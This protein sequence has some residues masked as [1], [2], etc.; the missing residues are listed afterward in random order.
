MPIAAWASASLL[1]ATLLLTA[2]EASPPPKGDELR[3]RG[4]K[5]CLCFSDRECASDE[6]RLGRCTEQVERVGLGE[7]CQ[8]NAYCKKGFFCD[9]QSKKCAHAVRC[10]DV[11]DQLERCMTEVYLAF[12]PG[13]RSKLARLKPAAKKRFLARTQSIIFESLC[14]ATRSGGLPH[15]QGLKFISATQQKD[16][17]GFARDFKAAVSR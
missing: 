12:K 1:V 2:C 17:A 16:C 7:E 6:C 5:G 10:E 11:R 4:G 9:L 15:A 3:L 13:E 14:R 8:S